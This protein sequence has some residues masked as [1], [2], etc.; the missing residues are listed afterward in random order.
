MATVLIG[1]GSGLIGIRLSEILE[2]HGYTVEHL[3]RTTDPD[4]R[5][6]AYAWDVRNGTIDEAAVER[7]DY[8]IN[9]AGAG[10]ADKPWTDARKQVI[11]ESRT[12]STRLLLDT[13][14]KLRKEPKAYLSSAAI[15]I[16]GDRGEELLTEDSE[17]GKSGFLAESC[18]AW[19]QAIKEVAATRTRTVALRIGV[20]LSTKGGAL[21]KMLIP[22]KLRSAAYFGDGSQWFPWVHIDDVCQ[23]FLYALENE[24]LE[25]FYNAVAPNPVRNK[26]FTETLVDAYGKSV[27]TLPAPAFALRLGMGEMADTVLGST[28][29]SAQKILDAGFVFQFPELK[30]ALEDILERKV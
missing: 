1:G 14:R 13:F 8:V 21:E 22:L 27:L 2:E 26:A 10:I 20:V 12:Q 5:F 4:A 28:K 29:V 18:K 25:G 24:S 11:I 19:E 16:Y 3:S 17:P 15:G 23:M 7:A 9:L 30:P 6:P